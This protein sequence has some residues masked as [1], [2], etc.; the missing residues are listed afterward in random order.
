MFV[1]SLYLYLDAV[2][3]IHSVWI[4][5]GQCAYIVFSPEHISF[6]LLKENKHSY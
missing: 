3:A 4:I 2:V 5:Y 1:S 6:K